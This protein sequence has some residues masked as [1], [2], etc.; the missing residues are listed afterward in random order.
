MLALYFFILAIIQMGLLV[1]IYHYYRS[2]NLARP[3][4]YW[5]SSLTLSVLALLVFG[6]GIVSIED[7]ARPEFNFTIANTFF[8]A[9]A[10]LQAFFCQSLNREV[11]K[12]LKIFLAISII[13]FLISI[14]I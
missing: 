9:A 13:I 8:Y 12:P 14:N 2:Q 6:G 1:G 11:G 10:V 3:N 4:I 7:I 5:M